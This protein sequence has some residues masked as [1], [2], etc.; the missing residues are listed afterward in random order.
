MRIIPR[1]TAVVAA[2]VV[3]ALG[4]S[5]VTYALWS[6]TATAT[7]TVTAGSIGVSLTG[8]DTLA[9]TYSSSVLSRAGTLVVTNTGTVPVS[10]STAATLG[11]G[12]SAGLAG[13]VQVTAWPMVTSCPTTPPTSAL[14]GTWSS[15]PAI[16]GSVAAGSAATWCVVTSITSA[17]STSFASAQVLPVL[18][19]T[20]T[21]GTWSATS[22]TSV[23]QTVS[24]SVV[25]SGPPVDPAAWG[26][27]KTSLDVTKCA[28]PQYS[29]G[30]S[31]SLTTCGTANQQ[32][33]RFS[34]DVAGNATILNRSAP[35]RHWAVASAAVGAAISVTT[36]TGTLAQWIVVTNANGSTSYKLVANTALCAQVPTPLAND[37]TL[38][39]LATCANTASQQ[40]QVAAISN[41]SPPSITLTCT[42]DAYTRYFSWPQLTGYED[43]VVYRVRMDGALLTNSEYSR[44]TAYDT[45]IQFSASNSALIAKGVGSH[46]I[47]VEQSV[48]GAGWTTTGTGTLIITSA[49]LL[50]CG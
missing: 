47:A 25:A 17:Q 20:A 24:G 40:F 11:S 8:G 50:G 48:N 32:Q 9:V 44:G 28:W 37:T 29:G 14:T 10:Y 43:S 46:A 31:L 18:T 7:A 41:P 23:T 21:I 27:I 30:T 49:A 15:L 2:A 22:S 16:S 5:G 4:A 12:S 38:L 35:T 33:W 19:A 45:T 39:V 13:A 34:Y 36:A 3:L 42:G 26:S 6:S 1:L